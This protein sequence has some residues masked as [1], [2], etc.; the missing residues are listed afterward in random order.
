M[1][2]GEGVSA[3]MFPDPGS[4]K[5]KGTVTSDG[6][7]RS[8]RI[9][10][11]ILTEPRLVPLA[12][13]GRVISV[14]ANCATGGVFASMMVRVC[15]VRAMPSRMPVVALR[16]SVTVSLPSVRASVRTGMLMSL[17]VSPALK[18]MLAGT[19]AVK[20]SPEVAV[21][22]TVNGMVK[23]PAGAGAERFTCTGTVPPD[24]KTV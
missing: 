22:P 1:V 2:I 21:P 14:L 5:V 17:L 15:V 23:P 8:S 13:S 9:I 3:V 24:S 7:G 18:E 11:P 10:T 4:F 6:A 20:S 19:R 16:V 12:Y